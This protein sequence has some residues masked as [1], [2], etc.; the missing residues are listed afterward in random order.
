MLEITIIGLISGVIGTGLGGVISTI[1]RKNVSRY[2]SFCM[3]ISGGVMLAVVVFDLLKESMTEAGVLNTIIFVFIGAIA[4]MLMKNKLEVKSNFNAGYLIFLSILLHNLP[5]GLA[6]GSSFIATE[7]LGVT[8]A[9]VIG[10]HNIP[11]G[12]A[13]ALSLVGSKMSTTKVIA[14]TLVAG[15]PMGIGSFLGAYFADMCTSLIGVFL[16]IAAG[17]MMYVVLEEIFPSTKSMYSI[18]GFLVGI[19]IVSY[20]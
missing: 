3:G 5:E 15:I 11:E 4:T 10:I 9:I 7:N 17:A 16:A 20:I 13:M 12:L 18:I 8:L 1:F 14:L 2:L 19:L 6:I